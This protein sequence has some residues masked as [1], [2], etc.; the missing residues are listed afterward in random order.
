MADEMI[1]GQNRRP[2]QVK[3]VRKDGWTKAR[4][5]RFLDRLALTCNVRLAAQ[6][7]GKPAASA[8]VLRR[9]DAGFAELWRDA[10]EAGYERLE[11]ELLARALGNVNA[12]E[13]GESDVEDEGEIDTEL[14]L[15]LIGRHRAEAR[16]TGRPTSRARSR[17]VA[18]EEET[19]AA[20]LRKLAILRRQME[21]RS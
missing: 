14:A 2:V 9:R 10:L 5:A 8:Y 11:T 1:G 21:A 20:L 6:A 17:H 4:R 12:I 13:P 16:G 7:A 18:T 19:N 15:K 3:R